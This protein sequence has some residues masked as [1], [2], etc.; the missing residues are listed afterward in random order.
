M[1]AAPAR[2]LLSAHPRILGD[3]LQQL[4]EKADLGEVVRAAPG[5]VAPGH[6]DVAVVTGPSDV[7]AD[8]VIELLESGGF[9]A[10][11]EERGERIV[12][13]RDTASLLELLAQ[14]L[15]RR[16]GTTTGAGV[17]GEPHAR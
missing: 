16:L 4:L 9:V 1:S 15:G 7:D 17:D 11:H 14:H 3:T 6:F 5:E 8:V 13:L 2:L 12:E 10:I